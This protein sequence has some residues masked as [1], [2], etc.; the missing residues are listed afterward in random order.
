M[1]LRSKKIIVTLLI[2]SYLIML[3]IGGFLG[4]TYE[5]MTKEFSNLYQAD[6]EIKKG[7]QDNVLGIEEKIT[8]LEEGVQL[9]YDDVI[10]LNRKVMKQEKMMNEIIYT[11]IENI[12]GSWVYT[13]YFGIKSFILFDNN[14]EVKAELDLT[15]QMNLTLFYKKG[16]TYSIP[17]K[18]LNVMIE[19]MTNE[20]KGTYEEYSKYYSALYG[21][22]VKDWDE[23]KIRITLEGRELG[24]FTNDV[25]TKTN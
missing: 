25:F 2:L 19:N 4:I 6:D 13:E 8:N 24:V 15:P 20:I 21:V 12:I 17:D 22:D 3:S 9:I 23:I 11:K 1:M 14:K 16:N 7:V 10:I 5:R 18:E